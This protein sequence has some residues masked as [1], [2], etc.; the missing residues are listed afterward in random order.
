MRWQLPDNNI[1]ELVFSG[2]TFEMEDQRNWT[3]ASYKIYGTPLE[4]PFPVKVPAGTKIAQVVKLSLLET[5]QSNTAVSEQDEAA[6]FEFSL[7][8]GLRL[9][10]IGIGRST[11]ISGMSPDE[12][13]ILADVGFNH[14]RIDV[15]LYKEGWKREF[16]A[17]A[18]ESQQLNLDLEIA[19]HLSKERWEAGLHD[20]IQ[21]CT[22]LG[23]A[24]YAI[25]LFQEGKKTTPVPKL[26]KA[27]ES[28]RKAFP[29][30]K[31]GGGTDAY[32]AEINRQRPSVGMLDFLAFSINPQVHAF[33]NASLIETLEAQSYVMQSAQ[34]IA[35][36]KLVHITPVTFKPR[37]NPNATEPEPEP[38]P[39]QLSAQTDVRQMSLFGAGWTLGSLKYL[40]ESG[41][42]SLTFFE[43]VGTKGIMRDENRS[44]SSPKFMA[45]HKIFP[46]YAVFKDV[47]EF[48]GAEVL[49]S[50]SNKPLQFDG[51][52]LKK[53]NDLRILLVNF[54]NSEIMVS[55]PAVEGRITFR[56]LDSACLRNEDWL[57]V[58]YTN[59]SIMT[60]S[61][62]NNL[63]VVLHPFA[64]ITIDI[65]NALERRQLR[66][67]TK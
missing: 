55:I 5:P 59:S 46:I 41:A 56:Q 43:T 29:K 35:S 24:V 61:K 45:P 17:A 21:E 58:L 48:S 20:F 42:R 33:D 52:V 49:S 40:S 8:P 31:I 53:G 9:P 26:Q 11:E 6:V 57:N 15:R 12:V 63:S 32:F 4:I 64:I 30:T 38:L 67:I 36:G 13:E 3:D 44:S 7:N 62:E 25:V 50:K 37:F 23:A 65:K 18:V 16:N 27:F 34:K 54:L 39:G 22:L 60:Y 51:I 28:L 14:Y 47:L 2:E 19:L 1:A 66:R 10:P